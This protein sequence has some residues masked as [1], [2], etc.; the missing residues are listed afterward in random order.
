VIYKKTENV[1]LTK[2]GGAS[3]LKIGTWEVVRHPKNQKKS[4]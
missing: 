4:Q 2:I 1:F 3:T